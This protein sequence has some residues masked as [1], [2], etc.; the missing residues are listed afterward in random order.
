MAISQGLAYAP[1]LYN[2][3]TSKIGNIKVK[4]LLKSEIEKYLLNL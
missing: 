4:K 1:K 3:G 2:L